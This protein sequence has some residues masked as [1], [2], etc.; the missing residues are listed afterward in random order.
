VLVG[1]IHLTNPVLQ[2]GN[3]TSKLLKRNDYDCVY[4]YDYVLHVLILNIVLLYNSNYVKPKLYMYI[5]AL[6]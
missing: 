4:N 2:G 5:D 1:V 6:I 3:T